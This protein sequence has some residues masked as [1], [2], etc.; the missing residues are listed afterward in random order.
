MYLLPDNKKAALSPDSKLDILWWQRYLRRFNGVELIY[1]DEPLNLSL[2]QLLDT[3]AKVNCGDAQVWGGGS[4]YD[5]EY[6]SRT[7]PQWLQ[8]PNIGIHLKEFYVVLVS[9]W[10]WGDKW[11]G[12]IVYIY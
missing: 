7:F 12:S 5:D 10:L 2:P 1:V 6:W 8:D 9:C 4:Y 11:T 3:D